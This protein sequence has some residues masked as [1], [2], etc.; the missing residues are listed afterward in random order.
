[1]AELKPIYRG[2]ASEAHR[3]GELVQWRESHDEDIRCCDFISQGI[4]KNHDGLRLGGNVARD[5][6]AEFGYDRVNL[7]LANTIQLENDD[8]RI[9]AANKEWAKG[10]FIADEALHRR[11]FLI[12]DVNPGLVDIVANQ[13]RQAY[14]Q[15]HLFGAKQCTSVFKIESVADQVL[16]LKPEVL[17]DKYKSP[18]CQLFRA[19]HGFGCR[20]RASGRAIYGTFL[21]D[22]EQ[23][24]F[25]REDFLGVLKPEYMPQW[26]EEKLRELA[27]EQTPEPEQTSEPL[28]IKIYQI[29]HDRDTER[30]C[31]EGLNGVEGTPKV[32]A[33]IYDEVFSGPVPSGRFDDLFIQ[34]NT[35]PPPLYRGRSMSTSDVIAMGEVCV[36]VD[37]IWFRDVEFD[38]SLA[39]KPDDLLRV[40]VLEPGLPAYEGE[41]G[42]DL[43]S[44]QRAV[45]GYIE[46]S[47]PLEGD[48]V[49]V[50]NEEAKLIGMEGNRRIGGLLYAGPVF[51]VGDDGEGSFVSLTGEQAAEYCEQFAQAEDISQDEVQADI[52]MR[53]YGM[54]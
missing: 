29:N 1:M 22:G 37:S 40:V 28:Y 4:R 39:Q 52:G 38:Q 41:I 42:P 20:P 30:I 14:E 15:L 6:I 54:Q 45:G 48:V 7:V 43:K 31:F 21:V 47:S 9:S 17:K 18:E 36:Y 2:T 33:S 3:L 51:I 23:T 25:N 44:M 12:D 34:F 13:A 10:F 19:E 5:A 35:N 16:V 49:V 11:D 8:G 50:G 26:A 32:D 27:P 53:F 46:V 24:R